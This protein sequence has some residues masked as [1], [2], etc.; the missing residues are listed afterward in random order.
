MP[1]DDRTGKPINID[2]LAGRILESLAWRFPVCTSSDEFHF[3]P[4]VPP[5][6][7]HWSRWDDF[8]GDSI[9]AVKA[10]LRQWQHELHAGCDPKLPDA[11]QLDLRL[12]ERVLQTLYE[13]FTFVAAHRHQPTF[14]LTIMGIGLAEAIAAGP[15]PFQKRLQGLPAFLDVAIQNLRQVPRLFNRLGLDMLR[16]LQSWLNSVPGGDGAMAAVQSALTR[17]AVHLE[18]IPTGAAMLPP[19]EVYARIAATHMGCRLNLEELACELDREIATTTALCRRY[20]DLVDPGRRWQTVVNALPAPDRQI[21]PGEHFRRAIDAL[22][23]H[24]VEHGLAPPELPNQ[25]PVTVRT[26][27]DYMRP[28]RSNAAF[29]AVPGHPARGGTFYIENTIDMPVPS[30]YRLLA[31]HETY[32]GH[33]LLDS[34]RWNLARPW[35]RPIEFPLFYEG[36]ASFSEEL[37]FDTG[38][39]SSPVD[40]LLMGKR[41]FWRALRGRIDFNIHTRRQSLTE[42]AT[43]LASH[44]MAP[45]RAQAMV[46]R[47]TLKPGYQLA[48][49]IG[50]RK[51][52]RLYDEFGRADK[53]AEFTRS[54]LSQGEIE[55]D[56]LETRLKQGG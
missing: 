20:A 6:Q 48:Y 9:A 30:D 4:Q 52:R 33:H 19:V 18:N 50:R 3:F 46:A 1:R 56:Q 42:A 36:W 38:F 54:V 55:F 35:R 14:Y 7:A 39:F 21:H 8:S 11:L 44:G 13:Q 22:V 37:L 23:Q 17:L 53:A 15:R 31:A 47:Y 2:R 16:R 45:P 25:C 12:L 10:Q 27:P 51:F 5:S 40:Q 34:S 29:S 41:R 24:C 28:V 49:T 43:F 26:I 32:P